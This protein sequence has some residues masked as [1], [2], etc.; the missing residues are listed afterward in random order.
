MLHDKSKETSITE[1][2]E[3]KDSIFKETNEKNNMIKINQRRQ[4]QSTEVN[5]LIIVQGEKNEVEK[6]NK[7]NLNLQTILQDDKD[8]YGVRRGG[9]EKH[10]EV[11]NNQI[12]IK[13][14]KYKYQ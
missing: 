2:P 1:I 6:L 3:V 4:A 14:P 13:K 11:Y 7:L 8:I 12:C 10:F 9:L 5:C